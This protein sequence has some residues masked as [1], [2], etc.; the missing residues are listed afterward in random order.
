M[1]KLTSAQLNS[2]FTAIQHH[3]Y[4][5]FFPLPP[6]L[7]LIDAVWSNLRP[8]SEG[9]DL[10]TYQCYEPLKSFC[11]EI[12]PECSLCFIP[13]P[14]RSSFLHSFGDEPPR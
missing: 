5:S 13:P 14:I 7:P 6:E 9:K 3:G 11:S 2:A 12:S 10:D 4:G 1:L 8:V